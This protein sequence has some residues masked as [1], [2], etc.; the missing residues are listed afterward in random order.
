MNFE[1]LNCLIPAPVCAIPDGTKLAVDDIGTLSFPPE[2]E[3]AAKGLEKTFGYFKKEIIPI[4]KDGD[5]EFICD[6]SMSP[7]SWKMVLSSGKIRI[8][9]ADRNGFLYAANALKQM[10]F[11][12]LARGP[13]NACLDCGT[14]EDH[15][16]FGTRSFMLDSARHFQRP[17]AIKQVLSLL[18]E[19]RINTFHWH[20]ADDQSWRIESALTPGIAGAGEL[21][22]GFYTKSDIISITEHAK[23]L[24]MKIIP[25]IDFPGHSK[26]LLSLHPELACDPDAGCREFCIGNPQSRIFLKKMLD[27]I[28]ELFPD[29]PIIHLGGDEASSDNWEKCPVCAQALHEK[30]LSDFRQLENDFMK[31]LVDYTLAKGRTPVLWATCSGQKYPKDAIQQVWLGKITELERIASEQHRM[32]FSIHNSLYFDYPAD[33]SEPHE[34]WMFELS[35]RGVYMTEPYILWENQL[36]D[37]LLGTE[38]C[39]WTE[40]IPEWRIISK[41]LPRLSAYSEVAWSRSANKDY[42]DFR[43]RADLL[44]AAGYE[45]Y[46]RTLR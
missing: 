2:A 17:D 1:T 14:V 34:S 15:P 25:E 9:S 19:F 30:N 28:M 3:T 10:L 11:T 29:S 4:S 22:D 8:F 43:R 27:E 41:L 26:R 42:Y 36:K 46:L 13:K 32:I 18:A 35:E 24:G 31:E 45:E 21:D 23:K 16:R 33:L 7:E 12:A 38:A 5:I 6:L 40:Y 20:L 37:L 44:R 39:L